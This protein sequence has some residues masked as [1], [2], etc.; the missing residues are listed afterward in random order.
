MAELKEYLNERGLREVWD[1]INGQN[2]LIVSK[3]KDIQKRT[4]V[5]LYADST[6][7]WEEN[8]SKIS[9]AGALY[10]YTDAETFNGKV[11][12]KVKI[13]DGTSS[14]ADLSFI[15]APYS[16]H[17]ADKDIHFTAEERA[18]WNDEIS[19]FVTAA[20]ES[21]NTAEEAANRAETAK[22]AAET[23]RDTAVSAKERAKAAEANASGFQTEANKSAQNAKD[24]EQNAAKSAERAEGAEHG[25]ITAANTAQGYV[26]KAGDSANNAG[27]AANRA[28]DFVRDAGGQAD[29]ATVAANRSET[30]AQ[31]AQA[32]ADSLP[33]DY[34]TAVGKIAENTAEINN[35]NTE[36]SELKGDLAN[37]LPKSPA[38]WGPWTEEEQ[39][40]ARKRIVADGGVMELIAEVTTT[41]ELDVISVSNFPDGTQLKLKSFMIYFV[42]PKTSSD[43]LINSGYKMNYGNNL[44]INRDSSNSLIKSGFNTHNNMYVLWNNARPVGLVTKSASWTN[45]SAE[46]E[47]VLKYDNDLDSNANYI[48]EVHLSKYTNGIKIPIGTMLKLYGVRV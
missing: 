12:A 2:S 35:T 9:E 13:G 21:A 48:S 26:A 38:N 23:A 29:R 43:S 33:D 3:I 1:I 22:T 34:V 42:I 25:A 40:E 5:G 27:I 15:D 17:I 10:I 14:L 18:Q 47:S 28:L 32:V 19:A 39:A 7:G 4:T 16:A 37:K 30:A 31:T 8:A 24:S 20:E 45:G 46:I 6:S 41:E 44:S 11:I 36:V